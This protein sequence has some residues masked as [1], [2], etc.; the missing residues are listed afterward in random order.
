ML[1]ALKRRLGMPSQRMALQ[2]LAH[3]G[4]PISLIIDVGAA[5]GD[6]TA[7]GLSIWP[8]AEVLAIE[9][10]PEA[11]AQC[12]R[13]YES[14]KRVRAVAAILAERSGTPLTLKCA[15]TASSVLDEHLPLDVPTLTAES[16]ALDDLLA[17]QGLSARNA[18]LKID[19]QGA[20]LS[21]LRGA[22]R[23]VSQCR[24]V[25]VEM[26]LLDI[27]RGVPLAHEVA[28]W[29]G[30]RG[31]VMFELSD[32]IRRPL[33]GALWQIE[34]LFVRHDDVLRDNKRWS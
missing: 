11:L 20:E 19:V 16:V 4:P 29:L 24:A 6:F 13:R 25:L 5:I 22:E 23:A 1:D 32:L 8:A 27:H 15:E 33:D 26:S 18:L 28:A 10:R 3:A 31:F 7:L 30:E 17:E 21:V 9:P 12:Q 14:N 34:A 2:K